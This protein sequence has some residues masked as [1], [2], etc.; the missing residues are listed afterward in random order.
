MGAAAGVVEDLS[1]VLIWRLAWLGIMR[2]DRIL[3]ARIVFRLVAVAE[4]VMEVMAVVVVVEED[5]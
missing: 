5:D 1:V 3:V 4:M 2:V